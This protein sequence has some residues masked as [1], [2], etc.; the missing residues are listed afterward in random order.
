M[1]ASMLSLD[2]KQERPT[3]M[4]I[5]AEKDRLL[6][7]EKRFRRNKYFGISAGM[8]LTAA[9]LFVGFLVAGGAD[10][11]TAF[12]LGVGALAGSVAGALVGVGTGCENLDTAGSLQ[13]AG[14]AI[15]IGSTLGIADSAG[16]VACMGSGVLL[17]V[18]VCMN[19]AV[20]RI[21]KKTGEAADD[22]KKGVVLSP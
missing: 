16:A 18:L 13:C 4:K 21:V 6:K 1:K 10:T 8:A 22:S 3:S 14:L 17:F 2:L 5:A 11:I 19:Y 15:A 12:G 20:G 7:Q 9:C